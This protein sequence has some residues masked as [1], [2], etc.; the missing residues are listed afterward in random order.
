MLSDVGWVF[1]GQGTTPHGRAYRLANNTAAGN[2]DVCQGARV[3][4]DLSRRC[5]AVALA[6]AEDRAYTCARK[7]L[8]G[9]ALRAV[10]PEDSARNG[11][12]DADDDETDDSTA[13]IRGLS[14][15]RILIAWPVTQNFPNFKI[16][17]PVIP[18]K[19]PFFSPA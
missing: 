6:K 9:L 11:K 13:R 12:G 15:Q 18:L 1:S 16:S 7:D 5:P 4:L 8:K 14:D 10:K 2:I 3:K 17:V 19:S